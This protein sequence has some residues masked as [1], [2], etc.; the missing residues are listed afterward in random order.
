[1]KNSANKQSVLTF[2]HRSFNTIDTS[3][4]Y[5]NFSRW[6][7]TQ[8]YNQQWCK[9]SPVLTTLALLPKAVK[10][11]HNLPVVWL[12]VLRQSSVLRRQKLTIF[13][14]VAFYIVVDRY[15]CYKGICCRHLQ[16]E[17]SKLLPKHSSRFRIL[18]QTCN[19][20]WVAMMAVGTLQ[21]F[22]GNRHFAKRWWQQAL[23]KA[24]MTTGT[25]QI[26]SLMSVTEEDSRKSRYIYIYNVIYIYVY[27]VH[28]FGN[29]V[30]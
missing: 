20:L 18:F 15:R 14:A 19:L 8:Y 27:I 11:K 22:G 29:A 1:M 17:D 26:P 4:A 28:Y 10:P 6:R 21:S 9:I 12:L 16:E 30:E 24:L 13:R 2:N 5:D 25:L 3:G 7:A 23:C